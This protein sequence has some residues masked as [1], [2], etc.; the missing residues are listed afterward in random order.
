MKKLIFILS[1]SLLSVVSFAQEIKWMTMDEALK[2]QKK[3]PKPIFM[4]V[5]TDWCGP[6]KMLDKNTFHDASI[7]ELISKNYYAVKFNAEGNEEI[8]FKGVKYTNPNFVAGK[9][10]RNSMHEFT[11]FLKVRGYPT[12]MIFDNK[13]EISKDIVGYRTPEQ[14][15]SEL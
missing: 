6:C 4:D 15:K 12:M 13:G 5:Y 10:G 9:A 14:L 3:D 7:V 2:A 11:A 1:L 8:N